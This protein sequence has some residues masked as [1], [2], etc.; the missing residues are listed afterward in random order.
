MTKRCGVMIL[1]NGSAT[2]DLTV[3][4][5]LKY[6]PEWLPIHVVADTFTLP[7]QSE[8]IK[9]ALA[10]DTNRLE[11]LNLDGYRHD[12]GIAYFCQKCPQYEYV[13]KL[14][15]DMTLTTP[16]TWDGL[17]EA[18]H[19]HPESVVSSLITP[20]QRMCLPIIADRCGF[21]LPDELK[22]DDVRHALGANPELAGYIWEKTF[23][24]EKILPGL[25]TGERF[26]HFGKDRLRGKH[27]TVTNVFMHRNDALSMLTAKHKRGEENWI[28]R[29]RFNGRERP[30]K[31]SLDTHNAIYHYAY[32]NG[33]EYSDKHILPML[34]NWAKENL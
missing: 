13:L 32:K 30:R 34:Q 12:W 10:L 28:H 31:I 18:Y 23:P 16:E 5:A 29:L 25:R 11:R 14:D 15:D 3:R 8:R 19:N 27:W 33:K 17:V 21:E 24:V 6:L 1:T 4:S 9:R 7:L 2:L 20:I 26:I 22:P